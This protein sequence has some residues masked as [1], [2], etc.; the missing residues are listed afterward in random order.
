M[1]YINIIQ[2]FIPLQFGKIYGNGDLF[3]SFQDSLEKINHDGMMVLNDISFF[4]DF[5]NDGVRSQRP[6]HQI[7]YV[8]VHVQLGLFLLYSISGISNVILFLFIILSIMGQYIL[9]WIV[10]HI[11]KQNQ[12]VHQ[13]LEWSKKISD[14]L[15]LMN[16]LVRE[17]VDTPMKTAPFNEDK[18]AKLWLKEMST[19]MDMP[20]ESIVIELLPGESFFIPRIRVSLG[21][22][23]KSIQDACAYGFS[24]G[25]DSDSPNILLRMLIL[26]SRKKK[27]Q[28][29]GMD[30]EKNKIDTQV[31]QL[32]KHLEL[33][34]GK[35]DDPPI[36]FNEETQEWKTVVNIVDRSNNDRKNIKQSLDIFIKI[37]NSYTGNN[38][39]L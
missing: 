3:S 35:R 36:L 13:T 38:R 6:K 39:L 7:I 20:W 21:G 8:L 16:Y 24:S 5:I 1:K 25:K 10:I 34:F 33:L 28:F 26:F 9:C 23:R 15:D 27:I 19:G 29:F 2:R 37:M 4:Q 32:V 18:Y 12:F 31:K 14:D 22:I 17:S 11:D 30:E